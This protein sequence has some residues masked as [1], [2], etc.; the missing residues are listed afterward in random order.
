[1][2]ADK[3][4]RVLG[5]TPRFTMDQGLRETIAWY[6]A[7]LIDLQNPLSDHHTAEV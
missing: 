5:W 4:R 1:M 3:A 6:T 2:V 7:A